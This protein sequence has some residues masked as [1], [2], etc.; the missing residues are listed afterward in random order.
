MITRLLHTYLSVICTVDTKNIKTKEGQLCFKERVEDN[1]IIFKRYE[2]VFN[3]F[4]RALKDRLFDKLV[5]SRCERYAYAPF[6]LFSSFLKACDLY[7][8]MTVSS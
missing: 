4:N 7:P 8:N 2:D 6:G 3:K 5:L 1:N